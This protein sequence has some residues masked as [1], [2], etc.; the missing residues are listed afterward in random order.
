[1]TVPPTT[2]S[3]ADAALGGKTA[4]NSTAGKNLIGAFHAQ[5]AVV[6]FPGF[7]STLPLRWHLSGL[8]EMAKHALLDGE[9]AV[10]KMK[11]DAKALRERESSVLRRW[12]RHSMGFKARV[13]AED[14]REKGRRVLL[15]A[16]HTLGH[17]IEKIQG[18]PHG[19]AVAQ[20]LHLELNLSHRRGWL[21]AKSR[22]KAV[23]L[24]QDLGLGTLETKKWTAGD[25]WKIVRFDKKNKEGQVRWIPWQ[26][27]GKAGGP[28]GE[29]TD[30][31]TRKDL[32]DLIG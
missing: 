5:E 2:L 31:L 24:L 13:V 20:G 15:N 1:M 11:K 6:T 19:L 4:I 18:I 17:A 25:V 21:D 9:K 3:M 27:I 32:E 7:L 28:K 10:A 8:A 30:G 14:F 22:E 16:G 26:A 29:F 23:D 12:I